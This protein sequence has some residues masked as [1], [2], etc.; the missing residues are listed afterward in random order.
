[1]WTSSLPLIILEV[2]GY[3][4]VCDR[5]NVDCFFIF[6]YFLIDFHSL[7]VDKYACNIFPPPNFEFNLRNSAVHTCMPI[8]I[9]ENYK[10]SILQKTKA[11]SNHILLR[12]LFRGSG[13]PPSN[14]RRSIF[15]QW[16]PS[17]GP[18]A[19]KI[20]CLVKKR[21]EHISCIKTAKI[22]MYLPKF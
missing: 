22:F 15:L 11:A 1:M 16:L 5:P 10:Y 14:T 17:P 13:D 20:F 21:T 18:F 4:L 7:V 3:D 8:K 12:W 19:G 6:I 9:T 2:N